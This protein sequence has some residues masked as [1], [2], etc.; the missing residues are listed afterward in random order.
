MVRCEP[1]D[2]KGDGKIRDDISFIN[3]PIQAIL[4]VATTQES[5]ADNQ[6]YYVAAGYRAKNRN[7]CA[8]LYSNVLSS[9][10]RS[11]ATPPISGEISP[12]TEGQSLADIG[13]ATKPLGYQWTHRI[14][15]GL[16]VTLEW[17]VKALGSERCD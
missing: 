10:P 3:K 4:A 17:Y 16:K 15:D 7:P 1:T 6:V 14:G 9:Y 8:Q 2:F 5:A 11:R 13:K 12:T